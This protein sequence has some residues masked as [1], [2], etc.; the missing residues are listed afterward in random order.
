MRIIQTFILFFSFIN[1]VGQPLHNPVEF[2]AVN[3]RNV[4]VN[5]IDEDTLKQGRFVFVVSPNKDTMTTKIVAFFK[6]D[7]LCS[8]WTYYRPN[9]NYEIGEYKIKDDDLKKG[10]LKYLYP[11]KVGT[12]N[13]YSYEG[14]LQYSILHETKFKPLK[15]N[16]YW[17]STTFDKIGRIIK[18]VVEKGTRSKV[19]SF[20]YEN[21]KIVYH[22]KF[23]SNLFFK[24]E[25]IRNNETIE[26]PEISYLKSIHDLVNDTL[27][28]SWYKH[29]YSKSLIVYPSG[30]F[31]YENWFHSFLP[32]V[33]IVE[34]TI[35]ILSD[36]KI[37]LMT[38]G[39]KYKSFALKK[40]VLKEKSLFR[41]RGKKLTLH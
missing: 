28:A 11:V 7:K 23:R 8:K 20:A 14:K 6:D 36:K 24:K 10:N 32:K 12:W 17:K 39:K 40:T 1:C 18:K 33:E 3:Y 26:E 37:K 4:H 29:P 34:G 30:I 9:T 25:K 13:H 27:V 35:K 21:D 31:K 19:D 41:I 15:S 5:C 2:Y 22:K 16:T 38:D